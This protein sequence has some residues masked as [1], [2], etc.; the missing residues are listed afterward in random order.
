MEDIAHHPDN[1]CSMEEFFND[2]REGLF[3]SCFPFWT[4]FLFLSFLLFSFVL[5][6]I[7]H[8]ITFVQWKNSTMM[9]EKVC[10]VFFVLFCCFSFSFFFFNFF[11]S[12]FLI[13]NQEL[14]QTLVGLIHVLE[15]TLQLELVQMTFTQITYAFLPYLPYF[16]FFMFLLFS[17][18]LFLFFRFLSPFYLRSFSSLFFFLILVDRTPQQLNNII[19][20]FMKHFV[21]LLLGNKL[22][23]SYEEKTEKWKRKRWK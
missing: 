16:F 5:D 23:W 7:A 14:F 22:L 13:I 19:K 8:P 9:Q 17:F 11:F 15:L 20:I 2:A 1:L 4:F 6:D 21:H 3:V 10:L 12:S 18:R